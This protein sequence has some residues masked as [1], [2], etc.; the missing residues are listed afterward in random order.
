MRVGSLFSGYGGLDMAVGGDVVWYSEIEPAACK[1]L[2][3]HHPSVPNLGDIK[4]VDWSTVAPVDVI[5]GGYPCQPFSQ[6]GMRKGKEDERHL[7]P[8]VKDAISALRPRLAVLENVRGHLSLGLADVIADLASVGYDARWGLVRA[9]DAGAPHSRARVFIVA[10]PHSEGLQ[11][12]ELGS[13]ISRWRSADGLASSS[14]G[15]DIANAPGSGLQGPT[16]GGSARARADQ[17]AA[18]GA[19][20]ADASSQRHGQRQDAGVVGRVGSPSEVSGRETGTSRQESCDRGAADVDSTIADTSSGPRV[21]SAGQAAAGSARECEQFG[22]R[23][24]S[25]GLAWHSDSEDDRALGALSEQRQEP[26]GVGAVDWGQFG[27]AIERW[28][29]ILGRRAASPSVLGTNGK[30]RLNPAFV[31]FMMGLPDGHV[32]G[33]GLSSAQELKMLGNGVCPQQARLALQML[34]VA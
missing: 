3:A 33:H 14:S 22:E 32:T 9:A 2:A 26:G 24:D 7:W 4:K 5:T 34:G 20:A 12:P 21:Q 13:A 17:P 19:L 8:Y 25:S 31:E 28:E 16:A 29:L 6:A 15:C 30:A 10:H 18:G 11:G 1:V 23:S 27:P